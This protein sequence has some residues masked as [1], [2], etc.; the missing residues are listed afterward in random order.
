MTTIRYAELRTIKTGEYENIKID[1][2]I[3]YDHVEN[4][5]S[6]LTAETAKEGLIDR[7]SKTLDMREAEI[8]TVATNCSKQDTSGR[9]EGFEYAVK[10]RIVNGYISKEAVKCLIA[11][12]GY[13]SLSA[14]DKDQAHFLATLEKKIYDRQ[15]QGE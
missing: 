13:H 12:Y 15:Q 14:I 4:S 6:D 9:V 5:D 11:E 2:E 7:V 1:Y 10:S 3:I 8:R